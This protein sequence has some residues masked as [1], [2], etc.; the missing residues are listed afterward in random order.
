MN[1]RTVVGGVTGGVATFIFSLG[2]LLLTGRSL[3]VTSLAN[4]ML[5]SVMIMLMAPIAGGFVAGLVALS[6]VRQAGLL[7]GMGASLV[8]VISWLMMSAFSW[9]A[10]TSGLVIVFVWVYLSRLGAG[11]ST[12]G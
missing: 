3:D 9:E 10:V 2:L 12:R 6:Q 11:F 4:N 5:V 8:V 1:K 7:A